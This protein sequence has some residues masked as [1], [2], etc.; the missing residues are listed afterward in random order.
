MMWKNILKNIQISGQSTLSRDIVSPDNE[1]DCRYWFIDLFN[2]CEELKNSFSE[3]DTDPAPNSKEILKFPQLT[4]EEYCMYRD[5]ILSEKGWHN[6]YGVT[7]SNELVH[8]QK[9][10]FRFSVVHYDY[11]RSRK[12]VIIGRFKLFLNKTEY[13]Y[14]KFRI[15]DIV[16]ADENMFDR[17]DNHVNANGQI[18]RHWKNK[19][20]EMRSGEYVA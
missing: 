9:F 19:I 12:P 20:S 3:Y 1:D 5:L 13:M 6:Y 14:L 2:I 18:S 11:D 8:G 15:Y 16:D 7:I 10:L 4:D 17:L